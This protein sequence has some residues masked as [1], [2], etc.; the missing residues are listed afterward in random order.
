MTFSFC[1]QDR[2]IRVKQGRTEEAAL[3]V[4]V[5]VKELGESGESVREAVS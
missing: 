2:G 1:Q 5:G 3:G 4:E